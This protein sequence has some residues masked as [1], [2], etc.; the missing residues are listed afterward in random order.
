A[1]A[2]KIVERFKAASEPSAKKFDKD[3]V[4]LDALFAGLPGT[5]EE[6]AAAEKFIAKF[7]RRAFRRPASADEIAKLMKLYDSAA[8][9]KEPF[10]KAGLS[11]LKPVLVSPAFLF[12]TEKDLD[13]KAPSRISD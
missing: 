9:R 11:M 5:M 6:R 4:A 10:V 7:A 8:A 3:R 2:D 13:A 12:R 1:A